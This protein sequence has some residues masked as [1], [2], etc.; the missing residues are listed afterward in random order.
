MVSRH[1][2]LDH[3]L[4]SMACMYVNDLLLTRSCLL[5]LWQFCCLF[6]GRMQVCTSGKVEGV[7]VRGEGVGGSGRWGKKV[8]EEGGR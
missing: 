7:G 3:V 6:S 2:S 1:F 8:G 5:G 4:A